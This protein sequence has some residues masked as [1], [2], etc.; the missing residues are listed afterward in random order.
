MVAQLSRIYDWKV[1]DG[2]ASIS[3]TLERSPMIAQ[4]SDVCSAFVDNKMCDV[5][6][7]GIMSCQ[8]KF[9]T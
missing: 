2:S 5:V 6:H 8:M 4:L 1:A 7:T 9:Q 3:F